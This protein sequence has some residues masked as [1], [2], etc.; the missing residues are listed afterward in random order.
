MIQFIIVFITALIG[1]AIAT[2]I[3]IKIA[4]KIG[5]L[6]IPKDNR[7]MHDHPIPRFGGI[8]VFCGIMAGFIRLRP[9]NTQ[10]MGLLVA[11]VLMLIVGIA[12][13]LK[14]LSPKLKL[15][16]QLLCAVIV[17]ATGTRVSGI[18]NAFEIG[19]LISF[20]SAVSFVITIFWIV[21]ITNAVNLVDGLDGLA[22]GVSMIASLAIACTAYISEKSEMTIMACAVAGA[23]LGFLIYNFHPAKIFMGD[24]GALQLGFLLSTISLIGDTPAKSTTLF[25]TI[26][27]IMI[28]ALPIF[29]TAFAIIR[30]V[31]NH[32]PIMQADKGHIH[33]RLMA[34]GLGQRKTV[35][36]LYLFC[37]VTGAAG[38][39]WTLGNRLISCLVIALVVIFVLVFLNM[40]YRREDKNK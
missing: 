17:W 14:G 34:M 8:A 1:T 2:P 9:L 6:D 11:T 33:H 20:P 36:V 7:R 39:S 32:K 15:A 24:A 18:T 26:V 22:A 31:A 23:C 21:G 30:R 27:P 3:A 4:P 25:A 38:I 29:D 28:L 40:E 5:A 37:I 35:L 13:D 10:L 19:E 16:G 12:D